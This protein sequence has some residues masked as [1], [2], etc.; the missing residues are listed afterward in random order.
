MSLT[1]E[2]LRLKELVHK[3]RDDRL[4]SHYQNG[5]IIA[6]IA[7]VVAIAM[8]QPQVTLDS[9]WDQH[10]GNMCVIHDTLAGKHFAK[11]FL[12]KDERDVFRMEVNRLL[13]VFRRRPSFLELPT[14]VFNEFCKGITYFDNELRVECPA[15]ADKAT[16]RLCYIERLIYD[17]IYS[18]IL[19]KQDTSHLV[20]KQAMDRLQQ[21]YFPTEN[22]SIE[23]A[24][25]DVVFPVG[26]TITSTSYKHSHVVIEK[27]TKPWNTTTVA[28]EKKEDGRF[29]RKTQDFHGKTEWIAES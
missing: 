22:I 5:P 27:Y 16:V 2:F 20:E 10:V 21:D 1:S 6:C 19:Y 28:C 14:A 4:S 9:F 12:S 15:F 29:Y 24:Y 23:I 8:R 7:Q 25:N 18:Q 13:S 3:Y 26:L 11:E 17:A